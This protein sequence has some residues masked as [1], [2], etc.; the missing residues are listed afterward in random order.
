MDNTEN[1]LVGL[2][3]FLA[4]AATKAIAGSPIATFTK[5]VW[6]ST[7]MS[8]LPSSA[9]PSGWGKSMEIPIRQDRLPQRRQRKIEA[10]GGALRS[11]N[12]DAGRK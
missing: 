12:Q 8:C 9:E 1:S 11:W 3:C 6:I 5:E 2:R 7:G 4:P 10:T